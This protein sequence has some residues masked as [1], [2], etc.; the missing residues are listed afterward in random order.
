M[1]KMVQ[2]AP[3]LVPL[4]ILTALAVPDTAAGQACAWSTSGGVSV[5]ATRSM[6]VDGV[7]AELSRGWI[8]RLGRACGSGTVRRGLAADVQHVYGFGGMYVI[9]LTGSLG[10]VY[11][12]DTDPRTPWLE[13]VGTAGL[14]HAFDP[15]DYVEILIPERPEERPGREVDL[16]GFGPTAGGSVRVGFPM[17]ASG[18]VVLDA[19]FRA[20]LL[21]T[22]ELDGLL[23]DSARV[24]VTVP[25][26]IGYRLSM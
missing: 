21:P 13:I 3:S 26:T 4:I 6:R 25:V 20:S 9:S 10:R 7:A 22:R 17:G 18:S 11:R 1:W 24:L 15:R 12:A 5:P 8:G 2:S 14:F 23:E 16:P 19:G